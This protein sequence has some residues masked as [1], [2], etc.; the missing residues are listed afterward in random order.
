RHG[1]V[2]SRWERTDDGLELVVTVPWNT[3]A[4]V[5]VPADEGDEISVDE[6]RVWD[7]GVTD[8][9][10]GVEEARAVGD[11]VAFDVMAGQYR[12]HTR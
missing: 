6:E 2:E 12:F 3:T 5:R 1:D 4:T 10:A 9:P 8:L 11:G 7:G